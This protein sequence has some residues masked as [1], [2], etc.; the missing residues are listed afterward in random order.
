MITIVEHWCAGWECLRW[1]SQRTLEGPTQYLR[2]C[3]GSRPDGEKMG[4]DW[5][6]RKQG[7]R[8]S[9]SC[10]LLVQKTECAGLLATAQL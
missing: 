5:Q 1:M 7:T 6:G 2:A 10:P 3:A 4:I 8:A 9:W